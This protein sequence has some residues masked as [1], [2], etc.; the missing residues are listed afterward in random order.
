MP[1]PRSKRSF[2]QRYVSK[3][4]FQFEDS[5]KTG[6]ARNRRRAP[7]WW[8]GA[9]RM[10]FGRVPLMQ[11]RG[12]ILAHS[13]RVEDRVLRKGTLVDTVDLALLR[14]AAYEEVTTARL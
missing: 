1:R 13:L 3:K 4:E 5:Y 2:E 6:G 12:G 7:A 10:I 8:L 11:A 14:T 9:H